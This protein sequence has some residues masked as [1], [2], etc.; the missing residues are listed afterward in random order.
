MSS[1]DRSPSFSITRDFNIKLTDKNDPPFNT[2][3]IGNTVQETS[4]YGT[5]VGIVTAADEDVPKQSFTYSLLDDDNGRFAVYR[6]GTVYK[7]KATDYE[8][9]KSHHIQVQVTDNGVPPASV[10]LT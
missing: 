2:R 3:L 9:D 5:V 8:K 10:S 7:T 4:P 6:N 1:D